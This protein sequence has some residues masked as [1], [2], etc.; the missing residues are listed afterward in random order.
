[1]SVKNLEIEFECDQC[2]HS[3]KQL[4]LEIIDECLTPKEI[5]ELI[6]EFEK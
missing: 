6:A 3:W 5:K 1:M 4:L 2:G